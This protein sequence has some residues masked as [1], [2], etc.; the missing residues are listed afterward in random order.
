M[1]SPVVNVSVDGVPFLPKKIQTIRHNMDRTKALTRLC[2]PGHTGAV[3]A[4]PHI[5][6][7]RGACE[8][9]LDSPH[10]GA[11]ADVTSSSQSRKTIYLYDFTIYGL[12]VLDL[13]SNH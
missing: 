6:L 1:F 4:V 8:G 2:S 13:D 7:D 10:N 3:G 11:L 5:A 9:S 12:E